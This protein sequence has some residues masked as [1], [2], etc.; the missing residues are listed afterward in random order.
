MGL[1][2]SGAW[3]GVHWDPLSGRQPGAGWAAQGG[4]LSAC[5]DEQPSWGGGGAPASP[6]P[7]WHPRGCPQGH[8][9]PGLSAPPPPRNRALPHCTPKTQG[10]VPIQPQGRSERG[11]MHPQSPSG[12]SAWGGAELGGVACSPPGAANGGLSPPHRAAAGLL[13]MDETK[14]AA[15]SRLIPANTAAAA[16]A[17]QTGAAESPGGAPAPGGGGVFCIRH[18]AGT[19]IPGT[20]A[21]RGRLHLGRGYGVGGAGVGHPVPPPAPRTGVAMP[22]PCPLPGVVPGQSLVG[23]AV[24]PGSLQGEV[25]QGGL[26]PRQHGV[27]GAEGVHRPQVGSRDHGWAHRV[28]DGLRGPWEGM[29]GPRWA[30]E[31]LSGHAGCWVG[32]H[33][34]W[35]GTWQLSGHAIALGGHVGPRLGMHRPW[36]GMQ[37]TGGVWHGGGTARPGVPDCT[38]HPAGCRMPG[39]C[40]CPLGR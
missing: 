36:V 10:G 40:R 32:T 35:V 28:L 18:A 30:Q 2:G 17:E 9:H 34:P 22:M 24:L 29:Q 5:T 27:W 15:G 12:H 38:V 14:L 39:P 33:Q 11:A 23:G 3:A 6:T 20:M 13:I 25:G 7:H 26:Q 8:S 19:P 16:W 4:P 21:C 37:V 31:V 1:G